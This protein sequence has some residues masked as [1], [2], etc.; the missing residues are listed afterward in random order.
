MF[1]MYGSFSFSTVSELPVRQFV[2]LVPTAAIVN[3]KQVSVDL[4]LHL[5]APSFAFHVAVP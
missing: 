3:S 2:P 4:L 1:K 5:S